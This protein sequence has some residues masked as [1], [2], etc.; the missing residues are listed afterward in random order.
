MRGNPLFAKSR[1][2]PHPL[3]Q[4][5]VLRGTNWLAVC[6]R[7]MQTSW[8]IGVARAPILRTHIGST[9]RGPGT[10]FQRIPIRCNQPRY[11]KRFG[12][13]HTSLTALVGAHGGAPCGLPY[14]ASRSLGATCG[15]TAPF[16]KFCAHLRAVL[17]QEGAPDS[18]RRKRNE[19]IISERASC[20]IAVSGILDPPKADGLL[21]V[22]RTI[23][24]RFSQPYPDLRRFHIPADGAAGRWSR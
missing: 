22:F 1:I 9:P 17:L 19:A 18:L 12:R 23:G 4:S 20:L 6:S 11:R 21:R 10:P 5:R 15:E 3:R 14:R 16:M 2:P 24:T 8:L 7:V 13:P